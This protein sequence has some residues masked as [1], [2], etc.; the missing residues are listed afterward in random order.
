MELVDLLHISLLE[1]MS[2]MNVLRYL[3]VSCSFM[4]VLRYLLVS[5]SFD[6]APVFIKQIKECCMYENFIEREST[7]HLLQFAS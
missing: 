7:N 4:N 1:E 6:I 5:S 3:L 2:F